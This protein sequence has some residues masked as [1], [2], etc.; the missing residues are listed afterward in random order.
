MK[1]TYIVAEAGVNHNGKIKL[2]KKM[3]VEAKKFGASAIKFQIFDS[4]ELA[5]DR[6]KKAKY[7][8]NKRKGTRNEN[9][10]NMLSKLA[11][12][13]NEFNF[14][15]NFCKKKKIKFFCSPFDEESLKFLIKI[16]VK[17]IKLA[18][19]EINNIPLLRLTGKLASKVIISS[20]MSGINEIKL[21]VKTLLKS[22]L[23]SKNLTI[24]HCT[25]AYPAP[26]KELNLKAIFKLKKIF[27]CKIGY[28]DHTIDKIVPSIA[29]S[30]GAE[31]IEKHFTLNRNLIGPDHKTSVTPSEFK[32]IISNI[33]KTELALG[34]EKKQITISE[35]KIIRLVRKSIVAKKNIKINEKF[36]EK[37]I[38]TKRPADGIS[39][40][41]WDQV[42]GKKAKKNFTINEKIKI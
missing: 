40:V 25:S 12:K 8:I 33:R 17:D 39:P 30:L 16:G 31:V 2:A 5:T 42:I 41:K 34:E 28:S 29:V 18:S 24:L 23:K 15:K 3:I 20:G 36:S 22:G 27:N 13:K 11:L 14:L 32:E 9:Q 38:T 6:A 21:A 10:L 35:K 37:N 26:L 19:G 4:K 1:K 7:Q